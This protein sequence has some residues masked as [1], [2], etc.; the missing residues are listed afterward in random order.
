MT[1]HEIIKLAIKA[2]LA[3][4]M[5]DNKYRI[6]QF[7]ELKEFVAL[8]EQQERIACYNLREM[9]HPMNFG[10]KKTYTADELVGHMKQ[11]IEDYSDMIYARGKN[12]QI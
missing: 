9:L 2:G 5:E 12:D 10:T 4:T 8:V 6:N 11:G 1:D 3:K 7:N